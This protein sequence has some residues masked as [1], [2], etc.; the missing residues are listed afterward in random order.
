MVLLLLLF[1]NF[2]SST[3]TRVKIEVLILNLRIGRRSGA[4]EPPCFWS[5]FLI[6]SVNI[7]RMKGGKEKIYRN[8]VV[9]NFNLYHFGINHFSW[10]FAGSWIFLLWSFFLFIYFFLI[11]RLILFIICS[12]R[13]GTKPKKWLYLRGKLKWKSI[14]LCLLSPVI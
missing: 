10:K 4:R 1:L 9:G 5:R 14:S 8:Y 13:C 2:C 6:F 12:Q 3:I 7:S 11:S